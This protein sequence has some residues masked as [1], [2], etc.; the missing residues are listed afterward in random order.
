[1]TRREFAVLVGT[2]A[3]CTAGILFPK[4]R[5]EP[6]ILV[7]DKGRLAWVV[8]GG[9]LPMGWNLGGRVIVNR[10]GTWHKSLFGKLPWNNFVGTTSSDI[11]AVH[12]VLEDPLNGV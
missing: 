6:Y 1:M 3:V 7:S 4:I 2:T 5:P 10:D 12:W 9:Q 8:D 11:E